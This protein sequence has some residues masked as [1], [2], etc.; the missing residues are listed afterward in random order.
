MYLTKEALYQ[1]YVINQKSDREIALK[2][3]I[4]RSTVT[5]RRNYHGIPTRHGTGRTGEI[6]A[7]K[8]LEQLGFEVMDMNEEAKLFPFDILVNRFLRV[9]VKAS[10]VCEERFTFCL[11]DKPELDNKESPFRITLPNGRSRKLYRKTCDYLILLGMSEEFGDQY[12]VIPS[13]AIPDHIGSLTMQANPK[14]QRH[15]NIYRNAWD[16]MRW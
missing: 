11:S 14:K 1:E 8:R 15:L 7:L 10:A 13:D 2:Y 3:G 4:T 6:K 16:S 5:K 9:E 12:F